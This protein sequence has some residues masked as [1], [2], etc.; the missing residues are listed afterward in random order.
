M[1]DA[2]QPIPGAGPPRARAEDAPPCEYLG[3]ELSGPERVR[4]ALPHAARWSWC[5]N[6][7]APLGAAVCPCRGCGP[8]CR[9]YSP[10][11]PD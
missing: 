8:A 2:P 5:L 7:D 9:G 11:T 10:D 1:P 4:L 3:D 6:P